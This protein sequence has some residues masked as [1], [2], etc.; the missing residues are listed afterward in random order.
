MHTRP[1]RDA[2]PIS[3]PAVP[4]PVVGAGSR[5]GA[6]NTP[7]PF[8]PDR[9]CS[10]FGSSPWLACPSQGWILR[11]ETGGY[12]RVGRSEEHTSELQSLMRNSYAVFCLKKT[13]YTIHP[14]GECSA[15]QD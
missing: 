1:L 10:T 3:S 8:G 9:P 12:C 5:Q 13:N 4:S 15:T 6:T 2:L 14:H 7:C 11:T